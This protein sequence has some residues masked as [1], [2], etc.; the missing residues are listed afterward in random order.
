MS[1]SAAIA[2]RIAAIGVGKAFTASDFSDLA[3]MRSAGNVL[4]RMRAKGKLARAVR[5]VYYV[6]E[7]STLI[8]IEVPVSADEV[9]HAIARANNW[10]ICPTGDAALNML[11]LD[12]QVPARIVYVTSG[13]SKT[14]TYSRYKIEL[15]HCTASNLLGRLETTRLVIQS[16]KALGKDH[17]DENIVNT[18]AR[19]LSVKQVNTLVEESRGLASWV[20]D[21]F[22]RIQQAKH[23]QNL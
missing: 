6:P 16:L 7:F 22:G 23:G 3:S 1:E 4:R 20:T 10:A 9:I 2:N 18:L 19:N 14:Y 11:G 17:M 21:A 8:G 13:P 12:T 15:K 5:G